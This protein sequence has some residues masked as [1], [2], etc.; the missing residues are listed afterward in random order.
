MLQSCIRWLCFIF[1][2]SAGPP[3]ELKDPAASSAAS[4]YG[5][6]SVA[7]KMMAKMGYREGQGL[8]RE[9]QGMATALTVEKTSRRGGKIIHE[10]DE[11]QAAS[12]VPRAEVGNID[13]LLRRPS[14]VVLL[15]N[16]VGPGEVDDDLQPETAEE[17]GRYGAVANVM[18]YE[19]PEATEDEAVRIFVEFESVEAASRGE[20]IWLHV[21]EI[22]VCVSVVVKLVV[23]LAYM[24]SSSLFAAIVDLNGRFF[25]G[26]IVKATFYDLDRFINLE[27][28]D[29]VLEWLEANGVFF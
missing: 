22:V 25:G 16:M 23:T 28:A 26:R 17:C 27:L 13:A 8:G 2:F 18:I 19:L 29:E 10:K 1:Q 21:Q 15:R 5:I 24:L 12:C 9:G 7:A 11:R 6:N 3:K 14:K 4:L 20:R